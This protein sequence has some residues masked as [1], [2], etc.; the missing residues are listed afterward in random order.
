MSELLPALQANDLRRAITDYVT[1]AIALTEPSVEQALSAF[2]E[3][4]TAGIFD[5]PYVRTRLPFVKA[6]EPPVPPLSTLPAWFTPYAHQA[7]AFARLSTNPALEGKRDEHGFRIP[8]PTLVTTGTGSGKTESFLFPILDHAARARRAARHEGRSAG[9]V[10]ALILYPMNALANDQAARLAKTITSNPVYGDVTAAL[11]TGEASVTSRTQVD[12]EGLITERN[13]IRSEAPDI[14]L[15]NYK[16][17]D[18]LLLREA[19]REL[20]A[21]SAETLRYVVLDEFHTYDGAQGTDVAM[22]LRRMRLLLNRLAPGKVHLAPVA[23]SA[24]LGDG[25]SGD[26]MLTFATAV[27]GENID[28]SAIVGERRQSLEEFG[29]AS[30]RKMRP[31][32]TDLRPTRPGA[33]TLRALARTYL[34]PNSDRS[35][36]EL[37]RAVLSA[38]W[39]TD[40]DLESLARAQDLS[41]ADLLTAHPLVRGILELTREAQPTRVLAERLLPTLA[42]N[43]RLQHDALTLVLA[44]LSHV[45]AQLSQGDPANRNAFP[46]LEIHTWIREVSRIN[47]VVAT[48]PHFAWGDD[49][50][51]VSNDEL[52]GTLQLPA[53]FC[54]HCG[55]SG[56]ATRVTKASNAFESDVNKIRRASLV[57]DEGYRPLLLDT[58]DARGTGDP[59]SVGARLYLNIDTHTL[60]NTEPDDASDEDSGAI[61][62]V[63]TYGGAKAGESVRNSTCPACEQAEGIRFVG[64]AVAT[65]LSVSLTSLFGSRALDASEKKAL[66]FTDS[67]QDAAHRAGFVESRSHAMTYRSAILDAL[68]NE[69]ASIV[70]IAE[71]MIA[72][73]KARDDGGAARYRLLHP[74]I[75][76]AHEVRAFWAEYAPGSGRR[77]SEKQRERAERKVAKRLTFDLALE[78]GR[79]GH[80]GRTLLVT[81]AAHAGVAVS[82]EELEA[83]AEVAFAKSGVGER[84]M[85]EGFENLGGARGAR[86]RGTSREAMWVR[87]VLERL[88]LRGAISHEWYE[89]FRARDGKRI[90]IWGR[91]PESA[92]MPAFPK[93]RGAAGFPAFGALADKSEFDSVSSGKSWYLDWTRRSLKLPRQEAASLVRPL[94]EALAA[95]GILDVVRAERGAVTY[96]LVPERLVARRAAAVEHGGETPSLT[97]TT[98]GDTF[99]GLEAALSSFTG[100]PCMRARCTG[101]L[102]PS[103]IGE[104]YYQ[105]LYLSD[106]RRVIAREHTSLLETEERLDYEQKFKESASSPGAP[107]V[108]VAT[109]TLEMGIDIGDLSTVMLASV[110]RTVASYLQRV[111]R[112]G[113]L[114]GNSLNVTFVP[115]RGGLSAFSSNPLS[116][117]NGAVRAPGAYLSAEEILRRQYLAFLMDL[118]A[119][120]ARVE[121]PAY[122]SPVLAK[123]GPGSF[124]GAVIE[125][126]RERGERRVEEFLSAFSVAERPW[127]GLTA[128]ALEA[129]RAWA[130][131]TDGK[132]GLEVSI[133]GAAERWKMERE[134]LVRRRQKLTESLASLE[135]LALDTA[136]QAEENKAQL[137]AEL[138][139]L[140]LEEEKLG[141]ASFAEDESEELDIEG[142]KKRLRGQSGRLRREI[143][144]LDHSHWISVLERFGLLPNYTL[145]DD[146]VTL[147]ATLIWQDDDKKWRHENETYDRA[148]SA[149]LRDLAPESRFYVHGKALT[150]DTIDLGTDGSNR[151]R[152]A[153]CPNCSHQVPIEQYAPETCPACGQPGISDASQHLTVVDLRKVYSTMKRSHAVI[154][155][156]DDDRAMKR[157]EERILVDVS[158]AEIR[159]SWHETAFGMGFTFYRAARLTRLNLGQPTE[160]SATLTL[161]GLSAPVEGFVVCSECG[162]VD[163]DTSDNKPSEHQA[164]CSLRR[165]RE[166]KNTSIVLA[167]DMVSEAAAL[168]LPTFLRQEKPDSEELAGFGA[169]LMLGIDRLFGGSI[170]NIAIDVVGDPTGGPGEKTPALLL[171][172]TVPGGTGYLA[173]LA[174]APGARRVLAAAREALA[175]C[176]CADGCPACIAS[177]PGGRTARKTKVL[178]TL[179]KILHVSAEAPDGTEWTIKE[180]RERGGIAVKGFSGD[181][182][183]ESRFRALLVE[184]WDKTPGLQVTSR[185]TNTGEEVRIT[186]PTTTFTLGTRKRLG[187]A[188]PDFVLTWGGSDIKGIA[189]FTDGEQYHARAA[190]NRL[191][192][193]AVKRQALRD[194]NYWVLS[195]AW[196]EL[197]E[198]EKAHGLDCDSGG[199]SRGRREGAKPPFFIN[200]DVLNAWVNARQLPPETTTLIGGS[201][202]DILFHVVAS[203]N[204][205]APRAVGKVMPY[206][207]STEKAFIESDVSGFE[208]AARKLIEA[209]GSR[210]EIVVENPSPDSALSSVTRKGALFA[211]AT[212]RAQENRSGIMAV[213]DDSPSALDGADFHEQWRAWLRLSNLAQTMPEHARFT[214]T[215]TSLIRGDGV[216]ASVG[217]GG[218]VGTGPA[219]Y[220]DQAGAEA[221]GIPTPATA[222][223]DPGNPGTPGSAT[224]L[225]PT[226]ASTGGA[227]PAGS[228][229]PEVTAP[230]SSKLPPE[231]QE[232]IDEAM[233]DAEARV[234]RELAARGASLPEQGEEVEGI[235]VDLAWA[236]PKIAFVADDLDADSRTELD[237]AGWRVIDGSE[238]DPIAALLLALKG[239]RP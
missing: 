234:L 212:Q 5:G 99:L 158:S 155:D 147:D 49:R 24:T 15:T 113:R 211:F 176:A 54:R 95:H 74:E 78:L 125:E 69:N 192:D 20:W 50:G 83:A 144:E 77:Y 186:T 4:D 236:D 174:S 70:E 203:G 217:T 210:P 63:L 86:G 154:S 185:S 119:G 152:V 96:A 216:K 71:R 137:S 239:E 180:G 205:D 130:L 56:W 48:A 67:V 73:A 120:D 191:A 136:E 106:M 87:G 43:T 208:S 38:L 128:E 206:L 177:F 146:S 2:L 45:R 179:E 98:C 100:G 129:F 1:T 159:D 163:P 230:S 23:T 35:P 199:S 14:L 3:H 76:E 190:H 175:E 134:E 94:F 229:N 225:V 79:T 132:H 97:C 151:T 21:A 85:I 27:F 57:G 62:P 233:T 156:A 149:A 138:S 172:D 31:L 184:A 32:E 41:E 58:P 33:E 153:V 9:G 131:P 121:K 10:K 44:A 93:G 84:P 178:L 90:W 231:W 124:L 142:E 201:A 122:G 214:M 55:R 88:R 193:D 189:V 11:Y 169:S 81:G 200:N 222:P 164:W 8:A 92:M 80:V 221:P 59:S 165:E 91:R 115:V 105:S 117:I 118:L 148:G 194:M 103:A 7:A 166:G 22:L 195:S 228:S 213:L 60:E 107:N 18:Q 101:N 162:H 224:G 232:L 72:R 145:V 150:I 37:T 16:M 157:Y 12:A 161:G 65:L 110:P 28:P 19:D 207:M 123:T 29:E 47:R 167:R 36:E 104:N 227:V 168:T 112:A 68:G 226:G 89:K 102:E 109:P 196:D 114:T 13:T 108:L 82:D 127:E 197:D 39:S 139:L 42:P 30:E 116:M 235:I 160:A 53:I 51:R 219:R 66:V 46:T 126:A 140:K 198:F 181:S 202:L 170:A 61:I 237:Q 26:S 209:K 183:F 135:S 171:Y 141:I 204:I 34:H 40:G 223:V 173:E 218:A 182:K 238:E 133:N 75:V 111:G 187:P 25:D 6:E 143:A 220:A 17:L 188:E 64:S 215:T 52:E